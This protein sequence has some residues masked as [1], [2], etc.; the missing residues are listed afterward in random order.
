MKL[1]NVAIIASVV[2]AGALLAGCGSGPS[3]PGAGAETQQHARSTDTARATSPDPSSRIAVHRVARVPLAAADAGPLAIGVGSRTVLVTP[4]ASDRGTSW[5]AVTVVD[6]ATKSARVVARSAWP[7]GLINWVATTNDWVAYVDQ[8]AEQ[9]P[10][11]P[12]VLWRV[13]AVN[14]VTGATRELA[15]SGGAP[16]PHIPVVNAQDGYVLWTQAEA[17]GTAQESVWDTTHRAATPTALLRHAEMTPGSATV[18]DGAMVFLGRN[19]K[20][21]SGHTV[22]GDCWQVPLAGGT[23][24]PVTTTALAMACAA[25]GHHVVWS[26]HADP[27]A[28]TQPADGIYD[29]PYALWVLDTSHPGAPVQVEE[30]YSS[31]YDIQL[32]DDVLVWQRQSGRVMFSSLADP[33]RRLAGPGRARRIVAGPDGRV[34]FTQDRGG[35]V[36]VE[37]DRVTVTP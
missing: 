6:L 16:S 36:T 29:N 1:G 10:D 27:A 26:Q 15:T 31:T 11:H 8:S 24:T 25:R 17:D 4:T 19:G 12:A 9:G 13:E 23:P 14:L 22:G 32:T 2:A 7:D 30:G 5:N 20:G 37:L 3:R 35:R 34:G 18:A 21:L 28:P 33:A